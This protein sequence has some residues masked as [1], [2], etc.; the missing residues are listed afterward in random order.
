MRL[1]LAAELP[2]SLVEKIESLQKK[3]FSSLKEWRLTKPQAL[4]I[5]LKFIGEE[6]PGNRKRIEEA[7]RL[8]S[9]NPFSS[10]LNE[11]GAFPSLEKARVLFF[12]MA[13]GRES[14]LNLSEKIEKALL[15]LNKCEER[16]FLPHLS[17]AR[18]RSGENIL[19]WRKKITEQPPRDKFTVSGFSLFESLLQPEGAVYHKISSFPL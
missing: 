17:I 2:A 12:D 18:H 13:E 16:P 5:T 15:F 1:F 10:S 8:I 7:L 14:F 6:P 3:Y 4:H 9:F 19:S 11:W